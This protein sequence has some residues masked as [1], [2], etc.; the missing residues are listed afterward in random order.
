[1][2]VCL[3]PCDV[4]LTSALPWWLN[5]VWRVCCQAILLW[6]LDAPSWACQLV[7]EARWRGFAWPKGV[8]GK[9]DSPVRLLHQLLYSQGLE[10]DLNDNA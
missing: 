1:V 8:P 4:L 7:Q 10:W 9:V 2:F 3:V 5:A 6:N